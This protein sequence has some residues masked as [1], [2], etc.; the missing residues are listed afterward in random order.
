[1][2]HTKE[3]NERFNQ[4]SEEDDKAPT[5]KK[6][7][8][9]DESASS[10]INSIS[11]LEEGTVN[12]EDKSIPE[13]TPVEVPLTVEPINSDW[14]VLCAS[15]IGKA[16]LEAKQPVPCQD[17]YAFKSISKNAGIAIVCDGA[18]S[19]ENSHI[20]SK[21]IADNAVD[22]FSQI[23]DDNDWIDSDLPKDE[24]W[25][26]L[27]TKAFRKLRYDLEV[28][29]KEIDQVV[30]SLACTIIVVIYLPKGILTAHI[31]DGRAA[32]ENKSNEWKAILNPHSGEEANQT[33]FI[34][35]DAWLKDGFSMND[36]G[37]PES[38]VIREPYSSFTLMSD[39]CESHCFQLG[40]MDEE[41]EK[42]ISQNR[43]HPEFF[44]PAKKAIIKMLDEG[45]S[46]EEIQDLWQGLIESGTQKLKNEPDDKT[47]ILGIKI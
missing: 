30:K 12:E 19:A 15:A 25:E 5:D 36:I 4:K 26:I 42:I 35:S 23:I 28:Y 33:I 47:I 39:G 9:V 20:G 18:G 1:M 45:K 27:S 43:P 21:F 46:S 24:D 3:H 34:T 31:G 10:D 17:S 7:L 6:V 37:V 29:S 22:I 16:H 44:N 32:F 13:E 11:S 2:R 41:Q 8:S 38:M 14:F 40:Y